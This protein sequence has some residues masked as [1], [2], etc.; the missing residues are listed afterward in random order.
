[1]RVAIRRHGIGHRVIVAAFDPSATRPLIGEGFALGAS[2]PDVMRLLPPALLR[3]H[4]GP[5]P[6]KAL[7]IPPRWHGIPVPIAALVRAL[8]DSGTVTHVWTINDPVRARELWRLGVQGIISDDPRGRPTLAQ[9][10]R[11]QAPHEL[12]PRHRPVRR[13]AAPARLGL[14]HYLPGGRAQRV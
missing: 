7:C 14:E 1:V 8:R 3:S 11:S 5:Q 13:A 9:H 2:T 10:E 4:V 6:F 12:Q